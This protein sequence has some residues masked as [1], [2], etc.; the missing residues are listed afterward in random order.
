[1]YS[2]FPHIRNA[3]RENYAISRFL[4][5]KGK[6]RPGMHN[7]ESSTLRKSRLMLGFTVNVQEDA[8]IVMS[9]SIFFGLDQRELLYQQLGEIGLNLV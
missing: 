1:V 7:P 4:F 9:S 3:H 6:K 2:S 5:E 8:G